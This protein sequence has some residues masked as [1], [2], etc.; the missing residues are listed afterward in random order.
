[1]IAFAR[2][3][4]EPRGIRFAG[5]DFIRNGSSWYM[6]KLIAGWSL[7]RYVNARFFPDGRLGAAFWDV[8]SDEIEKGNL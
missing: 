6:M 3:I 4:A 2:A 8:L 1:V 7:R 5:F